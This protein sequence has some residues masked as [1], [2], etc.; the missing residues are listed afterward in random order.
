MQKILLGLSLILWAMP[1]NALDVSLD[2]LNKYEGDINQCSEFINPEEELKEGDY[3]RR[4]EYAE[5]VQEC[6][7]NL[8]VKIF[9]KHYRKNPDATVRDINAMRDVLR[10][11]YA[12]VNERS[13]YCR[14]ACGANERLQTALDVTYAMEDY[15][16]KIVASLRRRKETN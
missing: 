12:E 13:V 3:F 4:M 7:T 5:R 10:L 1:A 15:M 11:R 2:E 14:P 6:Y 8:A 16:K 9:E